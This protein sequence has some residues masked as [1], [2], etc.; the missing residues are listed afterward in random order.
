MRLSIQT[1]VLNVSELERSI[2]FYQ[3]VLELPIV[4]RTD[5][6]AALMID[7]TNRRQV[8]V[9]RATTG[10]R[11]T[12]PGG[13]SIGLRLLALEAGSLDELQVIEERL[14]ERQAFI[15]RRR[16]EAWEF[17]LGVDPDRIEFSVASSALGSGPI[18]TEDWENLDEIVYT[19]GEII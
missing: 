9:L 16:T 6:V 5:Q 18:R 1:S 12:H 19:I 15:G 13:G 10:R 3:D 11:P 2:S 8:L 14:I 7:D 17:V 4:S